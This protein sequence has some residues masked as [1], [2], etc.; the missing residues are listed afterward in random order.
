MYTA[1]FIHTHRILLDLTIKQDDISYMKSI[2]SIFTQ[3][4]VK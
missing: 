4:Y 1:I 3:I 2:L